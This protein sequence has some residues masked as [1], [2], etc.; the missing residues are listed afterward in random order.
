MMMMIMF[1]RGDDD[2][3][4]DEDVHDDDSFNP[5]HK[6]ETPHHKICTDPR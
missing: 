2:G 4:G 6:L 5:R 3:D 1:L